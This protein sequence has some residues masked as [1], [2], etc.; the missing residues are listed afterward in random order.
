MGILHTAEHHIGAHQPIPVALVIRAIRPE[1]AWTGVSILADFRLAAAH[2]P[3]IVGVGWRTT[4][5]TVLGGTPIT[6]TTGR[7]YNVIG[8]GIIGG[9]TRVSRWRGIK[10]HFRGWWELVGLLN[11]CDELLG[12][13]PNGRDVIIIRGISGIL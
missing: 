10:L 9:T 12:H 7:T 13:T 4:D 1:E 2:P 6:V 5:F 8:R 3:I 11:I